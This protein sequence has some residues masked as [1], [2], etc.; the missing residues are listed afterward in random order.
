MESDNSHVEKVM[1]IN[2]YGSAYATKAVVPY[3]QKRKMGRIVYVS[4]ILGL[5]GCPGYAVYS[6]SKF[7]LKG[8]AE[9]LES[10]LSPFGIHL[11][12]AVPSNVDT[13]MFEEE[14]KTKP[15]ETKAIEVGQRPV[16]AK[17][18]AD[19]IIASFKHYRFLIPTTI[20]P[21]LMSNI[22]AG[23]CPASFHEFLTQPLVAFFGR[24]VSLSETNKYRLL[25]N[26]YTT[27]G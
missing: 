5:M 12:V 2:F 17:A 11:S 25:S 24:F 14:E 9:S 10:E 3:M 7:A 26:K 1:K 16:K 21:W 23:F 13:P 6:A 18:V 27:T 15:P 4:S 8:F 22:A 20:D 19:D